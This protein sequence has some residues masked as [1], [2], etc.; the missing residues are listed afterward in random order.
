MKCWSHTSLTNVTFREKVIG[1]EGILTTLYLKK[2]YILTLVDIEK[3]LF[4]FIKKI[5][6]M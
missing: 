1:A 6:F 4:Y 3:I 2:E 5:L